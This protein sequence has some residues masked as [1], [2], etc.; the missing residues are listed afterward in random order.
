MEVWGGLMTELEHTLRTANIDSGDQVGKGVANTLRAQLQS[1]KARWKGGIAQVQK[2]Q[3]NLNM[4]NL[5]CP[6]YPEIYYNQ[7]TPLQIGSC[8]V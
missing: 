4:E 7:G 2:T 6:P 8:V 5:V 3:R 1:G